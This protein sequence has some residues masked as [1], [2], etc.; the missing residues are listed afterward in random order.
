MNNEPAH[1]HQKVHA[2]LRH[3]PMGIL[4]TVSADGT[5][6]GSAIY[7]VADE[8]FKFYFVTR[9]GTFKFDNIE[10]NPMAAITVADNESQT[11][12]QA[13]GRIMRLPYEEYNE[14]V[15]N[16]LGNLRPK[17]DDNWSFP[18]SK[19]KKGNYM[20]LYLIPDRLQFAD[21]K[22]VK[23]DTHADYIERIIPA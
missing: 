17:D 21:Y 9:V 8:D 3:H 22:N 2:F 19:L 20:P 6:W 14:I 15:F 18:L 10:K 23:S 11:T 12:V 13:S 1:P 7:Y 16:K 4:S 5:P